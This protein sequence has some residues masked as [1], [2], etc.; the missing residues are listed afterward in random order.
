[1]EDLITSLGPVL[2]E[3]SVAIDALKDRIRELVSWAEAEGEGREQTD[4]MSIN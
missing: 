1:M 3:M 4:R 2:E